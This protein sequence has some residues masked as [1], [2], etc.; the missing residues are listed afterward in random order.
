MSRHGAMCDCRMCSEKERAKAR[1]VI[2]VTVVLALT[3]FCLAVGIRD[4]LFKFF[5]YLHF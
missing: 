4:G 5:A 2:S 3:L 1:A